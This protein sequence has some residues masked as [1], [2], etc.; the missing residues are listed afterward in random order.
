VSVDPERPSSFNIYISGGMDFTAC[1]RD[2]TQRVSET[3]SPFVPREIQ[4]TLC[5]R[6]GIRVSFSS[7]SIKFVTRRNIRKCEYSRLLLVR[8]CLFGTSAP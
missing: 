8:K 6:D 3:P 7:S 4:T 5:M 1:N 2:Q